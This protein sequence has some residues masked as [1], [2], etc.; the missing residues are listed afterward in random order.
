MGRGVSAI[1]ED[2]EG[3]YDV[4]DFALPALFSRR[5]PVAGR[6]GRGRIKTQGG[7][8]ER[9]DRFTCYRRFDGLWFQAA[10]PI[11]RIPQ[12][13]SD[14][15]GYVPAGYSGT[16]AEGE[17]AGG[18]GWPPLHDLIFQLCEDGTWTNW[19]GFSGVWALDDNALTIGNETA[20]STGHIFLSRDTL[21]LNL[22]G[23]QYVRLV[24]LFRG[25][26]AAE[27][28]DVEPDARRG[29]PF[30]RVYAEPG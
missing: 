17:A 3:F 6:R 27:G 13:H 15:A 8:Y 20:S 25:S 22:T 9:L 1:R 28:L 4:P 19:N 26:K 21:Y 10:H 23:D 2:A 24:L 14:H 11:S 12:D 7:S 16:M 30:S 18:G 5:L 29:V